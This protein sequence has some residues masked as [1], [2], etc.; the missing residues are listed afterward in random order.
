MACERPQGDKQSGF[1]DAG[2]TACEPVALR[3]IQFHARDP[4]SRPQGSS[5]NSDVPSGEEAE[6]GG[7]GACAELLV[8]QIEEGDGQAEDKE[9]NDDEAEHLSRHRPCERCDRR[10]KKKKNERAPCAAPREGKKAME[11]KEQR[12]KNEIDRI[13]FLDSVKT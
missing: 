7:D 6:G 4:G 2:T 10:K 5:R 9:E 3:V 11:K 1:D 12:R 13:F 8:D